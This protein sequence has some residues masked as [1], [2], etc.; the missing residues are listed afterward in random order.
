MDA[1]KLVGMTMG[2]RKRAAWRDAYGPVCHANGDDPSR[3]EMRTSLASVATYQ[4]LDAIDIVDLY[5]ACLVSYRIGTRLRPCPGS[6]YGCSRG[7]S[8]CLRC[9]GSGVVSAK[10]KKVPDEPA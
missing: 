7:Q 9:D 8:W 6:G 10:P 1:R 3:R 2:A 4:H 5:K